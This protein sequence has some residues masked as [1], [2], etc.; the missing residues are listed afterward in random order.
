MK[1][2]VRLIHTESGHYKFYEMEQMSLYPDKFQ[3][4]YGK[5]DT[6]GSAAIYQMS[7]W[8]KK[9]KEK[10]NKGYRDVSVT[11]E[12]FSLDDVFANLDKLEERLK[13]N[14]L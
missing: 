11:I 2:K 7:L 6:A 12:K 5:I 8:D 1:D 14:E 13:A 9:Y 3:V 4:R 10:I